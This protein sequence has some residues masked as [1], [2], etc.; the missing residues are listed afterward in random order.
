MLGVFAALLGF[1][2]LLVATG[3]LLLLAQGARG[4]GGHPAALMGMQRREV[5]SSLLL[6]GLVLG[7]LGGLLVGVGPAALLLGPSRARGIPV[8]MTSRNSPS[9]G[10]GADTRGSEQGTSSGWW[11]ACWAW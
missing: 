11:R 9:A 7:G 5:F 1:F 10:R 6:E 4:R 2:V 3:T 8:M